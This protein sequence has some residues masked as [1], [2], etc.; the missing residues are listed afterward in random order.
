[1][2]MLVNNNALIPSNFIGEYTFR[3]FSMKPAANYTL[4][5]ECS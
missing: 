1:M 4:L 5:M 2:V 3:D